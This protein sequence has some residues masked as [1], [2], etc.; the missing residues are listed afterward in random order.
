MK[1]SWS[2]FDNEAMTLTSIL[3]ALIVIG[4]LVW[5]LQSLPIAEPFKSIAY[6]VLVVILILWLLG[7]VSIGV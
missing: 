2:G 5:L 4:L 3:I 7:K 1:T 6:V